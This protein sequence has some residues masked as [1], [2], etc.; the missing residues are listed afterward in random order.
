MASSRFLNCEAE[1]YPVLCRG[2]L[3]LSVFDRAGGGAQAGQSELNIE[4]LHNARAAGATGALLAAGRCAWVD[5]PFSAKEPARLMVNFLAED[6]VRSEAVGTTRLLEHVLACA[7]NADCI[8]GLCARTSPDSR[9]NPTIGEA[10]LRG[11]SRQ[12][13]FGYAAPAV[14]SLP[15]Q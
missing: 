10:V 1:S 13:W 12:V 14:K 2:P 7:Q 4:V 3:N 9:L 5:R 15:Q 11:N 6:R 8:I